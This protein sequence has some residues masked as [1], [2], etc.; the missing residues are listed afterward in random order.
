MKNLLPTGNHAG[1]ENT[2]QR[3][4]PV[5]LGQ[6]RYQ[7][8]FSTALHG[9]GRSALCHR[10]DQRLVVHDALFIFPQAQYNYNC[11]R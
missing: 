10:I 3:R 5:C 11:W 2:N 9:T 6:C 4:R 1:L 7:P 8:R